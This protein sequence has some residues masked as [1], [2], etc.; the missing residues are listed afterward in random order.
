[1][2]MLEDQIFR[3]YQANPQ[4]LKKYGFKNQTGVYYYQENFFDNKFQA[5][6]RIKKGRLS[7]KVIDRDMGDEYLPLHSIQT[8]KFVDSVRAAYVDVLKKIR[9]NCFNPFTIYPSDPQRYWLTPANLK[10]YDIMHAFDHTNIIEWKQSTKVKVGDIVFLYVTQPYSAIIYQCQVLQVGIPYD[11]QTKGLRVKQVMK[12]RKIK[13]YPQKRFT[14]KKIT[15]LG[16]KYVMGPR[17]VPQPL[18]KELL[19]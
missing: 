4:K 18:L 2:K 7:G 11:Y 17:H 3:Q 14:L 16:V 8:G 15:P 6:I 19:R 10:Y 5:Q 13:T 12:V 9:Q 1:M